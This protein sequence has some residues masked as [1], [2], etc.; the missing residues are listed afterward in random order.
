M[1]NITAEQ[2]NIEG[3]FVGQARKRSYKK[4]FFI[5]YLTSTFLF[6]C[7]F[8]AKYKKYILTPR[9]KWKQSKTWLEYISLEYSFT[10]AQRLV[11]K[12][13][14]WYRAFPNSGSMIYYKQTL[15]KHSYKDLILIRFDFSFLFLKRILHLSTF[16][17][18]V[19]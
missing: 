16:N 9:W 18:L 7:S 19:G 1:R 4:V 2:S 15:R 6:Y 12:N 13:I 5:Y 11:N 8:F 10:T 17:M 3:K 14:T